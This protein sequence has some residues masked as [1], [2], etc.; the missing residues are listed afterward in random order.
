MESKLLIIATQN[1][2]KVE[3]LE[4]LLTLNN[5]NEYVVKSLKDLNIFD[6]VI[7]DGKTLEENALIKVNGYSKIIDE[8]GIKDYQIIADDTG[9]FVES[10]NG[11]PGIYSARYATGK[12][13]DKLNREKLL[14]NLINQSNRNAYFKCVICFKKENKEI[15]NFIGKTDGFILE[16]EEGNNGF[17]YD[18]IFYSQE[19]NKSFG[20]STNIEKA[21]VSHRGKA[22]KELIKY[23]KNSS[24]KY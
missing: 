9:L 1:S 7:E 23:L 15:I 5:L 6:D 11:E 20:K 14:K 13:N 10:L 8:M 16:K 4:M 24:R 22:M 21:S 3:E 17:G 19:L 2:H 18:S 12:S